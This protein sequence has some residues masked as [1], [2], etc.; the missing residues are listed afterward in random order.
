MREISYS[1]GLLDGKSTSWHEYGALE[2]EKNYKQGKPHGKFVF[3]G[4]KEGEVLNTI[5][6]KEGERISEE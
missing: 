2:S 5:K 3:Y 6:F 1:N 4:R